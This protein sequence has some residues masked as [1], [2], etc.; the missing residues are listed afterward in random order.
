LF[1]QPVGVSAAAELY[2]KRVNGTRHTSF[3]ITAQQET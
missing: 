1:G 3:A 2:S